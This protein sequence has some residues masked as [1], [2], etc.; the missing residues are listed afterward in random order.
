MNLIRC[1]FPHKRLQVPG[2]VV[3]LGTCRSM[4][5]CICFVSQSVTETSVLGGLWHSVMMVGDCLHL[6]RFCFQESLSLVNGS[7]RGPLAGRA[8][9]F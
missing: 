4:L 3:L 2:D 6:G 5:H 8:L 9:G 7:E 1:H